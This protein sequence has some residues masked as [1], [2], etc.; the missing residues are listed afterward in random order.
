MTIIAST[1]GLQCLPLMHDG[2]DAINRLPQDQTVT[3]KRSN[4]QPPR[5]LKEP[6]T[7]VVDSSA[8]GWG[9]GDLSVRDC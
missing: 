4:L 1:N 9:E 7:A 3:P 8:T 2:T 5:E 6:M